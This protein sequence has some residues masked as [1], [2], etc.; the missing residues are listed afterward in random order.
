MAI[1]INFQDTFIFVGGINS[2]VQNNRSIIVVNVIVSLYG[3]LVDSDAISKLTIVCL[4]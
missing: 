3:L 1:C 2:F 4:M